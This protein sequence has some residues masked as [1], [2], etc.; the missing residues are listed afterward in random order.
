MSTQITIP[1][2]YGYVLLTASLSTLVG[3]WHILRTG[4]YRK[5]AKVPYPNHYATAAEAKES[6]EKYLFNCS[7]RSHVTFIEV[8]TSSQLPFHTLLGVARARLD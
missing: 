5:N 2:E 6:K 4:G 1:S 7:Q 8:R 3:Y